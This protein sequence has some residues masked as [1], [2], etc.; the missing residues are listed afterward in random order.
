MYIQES[1]RVCLKICFCTS[2]QLLPDCSSLRGKRQNALLTYNVTATFILC[3]VESY[4]EYVLGNKRLIH[5]ALQ[6]SHIIIIISQTPC[7]NVVRL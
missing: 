2:D 1:V 5:T 4:L 7:S 3:L 6:S